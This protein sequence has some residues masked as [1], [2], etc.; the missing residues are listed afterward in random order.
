MGRHTAGSHRDPQLHIARSIRPS[1]QQHPWS[2][3]RCPHRRNASVEGDHNTH[4]SFPPQPIPEHARLHHT[5]LSQTQQIS[6]FST[7]EYLGTQRIRHKEIQVTICPQSIWGT[8]LFYTALWSADVQ[9]TS[10][11]HRPLLTS[12]LQDRSAIANEGS[13]GQCDQ[14]GDICSKHEGADLLSSHK[15]CVCNLCQLSWESPSSSA[16]L[17]P[18]P[19]H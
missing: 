7:Q 19:L 2:H 11:L 6:T 14:I 13:R 3:S 18:D 5:D 12:L 16:D 17:G 10:L 8:V 9:S 4:Q 1:S 15:V